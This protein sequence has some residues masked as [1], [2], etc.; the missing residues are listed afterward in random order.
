MWD[1]SWD[2]FKWLLPIFNYTIQAIETQRSYRSLEDDTKSNGSTFVFK[3]NSA[4]ISIIFRHDFIKPQKMNITS[5]FFP[6][7][8][9]QK[10]TKTII[11]EK[12]IFLLNKYNI[13]FNI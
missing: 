6:P 11:F 10:L 8:G 7:F 1:E 12:G 13:R 9:T 5:A 3:T 2:N 4:D